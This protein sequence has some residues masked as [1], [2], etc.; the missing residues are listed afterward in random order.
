MD[1]ESMFDIVMC[2]A[3]LL[4]FILGYICCFVIEKKKNVRAAKIRMAQ[5]DKDFKELED[6]YYSLA[7][8]G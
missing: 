6:L 4:N 1:K 2:I 3:I 5:N 7:K 8:K